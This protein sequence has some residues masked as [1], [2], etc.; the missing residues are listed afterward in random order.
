VNTKKSLMPIDISKMAFR[1]LGAIRAEWAA[2]DFS[3]PSDVVRV[4]AL[5]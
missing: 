3:R 2:A 4:P 1:A 5:L